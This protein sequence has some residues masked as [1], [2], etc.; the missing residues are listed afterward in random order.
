MWQFLRP[1]IV[2]EALWKT[3]PVVAG[4]VGGIPMQIPP[5]HESF[6]V[7]SVEACVDKLV[8]LL[9]DAELRRA[10]GEAGRRHVRERY[11]LPRLV[12]D[13]L[14]VIRSLVSGPSR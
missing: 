11:L 6:L 7:N 10:H 14:R 2:S 4:K 5:G 13:D 12:R 3:R 9:R 1:L 8:E